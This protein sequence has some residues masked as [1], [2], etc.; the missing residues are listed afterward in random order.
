MKSNWLLFGETIN[1]G[2]PQMTDINDKL[3][4]TRLKLKH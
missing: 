2:V 4:G 1:T 3:S